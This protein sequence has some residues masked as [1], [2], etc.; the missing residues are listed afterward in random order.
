MQGFGQYG[1]ETMW[2]FENVV[3]RDSIPSKPTM[4]GSAGTQY[5]S[6][7]DGYFWYRQVLHI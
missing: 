3:T 4:N 2:E 1:N 7:R 6:S 5:V